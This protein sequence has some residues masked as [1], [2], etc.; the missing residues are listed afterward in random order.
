MQ[1]SG[2]LSAAATRRPAGNECLPPLFAF[3]VLEKIDERSDFGGAQARHMTSIV[4]IE[5][6]LPEDLARFRLP[7]G[8]QERLSTLLDKQDRGQPL[9]DAEQREAEGLVDLADL[10]SLLRLRAERIGGSTE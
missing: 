3:D 6:E 10:L 5:I 7:E 9:T 1:C 8:V 2:W 4:Q